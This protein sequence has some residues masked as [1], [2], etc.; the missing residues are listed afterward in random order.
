MFTVSSTITPR[1]PLNSQVIGVSEPTLPEIVTTKGNIHPASKNCAEKWKNAAF[2]M[3]EHIRAHFFFFLMNN[4]SEH[5]NHITNQISHHHK[6]VQ[7]EAHLKAYISSSQ[8]AWKTRGQFTSFLIHFLNSRCCHP[9]NW[10]WRFLRLLEQFT[11]LMV[12]IREEPLYHNTRK[13]E[14]IY[15]HIWTSPSN[16]DNSLSGPTNLS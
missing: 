5:T 13:E 4:I 1:K 12:E 6:K 11:N 7:V 8:Q 9:K 16:V 2:I 15:H 14:Y 10:V 3:R